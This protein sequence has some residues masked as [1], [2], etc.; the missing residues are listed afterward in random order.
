[1]LAVTSLYGIDLLGDN[2]AACRARLGAVVNEAH[3]ALF[4]EALPDVA[5]SAIAYIL[6][7][8]VVQGDALSF[9][10]T[11]GGAIILPEWSPLN[12]QM[13]KRRDFR[14]DHLL[15]HQR[16]QSLPLFSDLGEEVYLPEPVR[17]YR[18]CHFLHVAQQEVAT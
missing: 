6:S 16:V 10:T 3:K 9:R 7:Q 18:P 15:E 2:V 17:D 14:F 4:S 12:G 8:N 5:N 13:L 1:M 11:D